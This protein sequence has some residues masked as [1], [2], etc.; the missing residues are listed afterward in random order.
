M[1]NKKQHPDTNAQENTSSRRR[2]VFAVKLMIS[3]T[4]LL[5]LI[6]Q[7]DQQDLL[8][9]VKSLPWWFVFVAWLYY[10][11]CQWISAYRWQIFL[12]VKNIHVPLSKLFSFYMVGMFLNNFLPSAVG[13]DVVKTVD[14]YRYTGRGNYAI[15]SVFLE[16]YTG[17]LGLTIIGVI[18]ALFTLRSNDS[19]IVLFSVVGTAAFLV[20]FSVL[21]WCEPLV[22][23]VVKAFSLVSPRGLAAKFKNLFEAIHSYKQHPK[24]LLLTIAVS[25]VL[26]LMFAFYYGLFAQQLGIDVDVSYFIL[27]LPVITLVTMLPLSVGGLGVREA[28]MVLLF[29]QVGIASAEILSIS[30]TVHVVNMGLSLWGGL[31]FA[32][33]GPLAKA[34]DKSASEN[35]YV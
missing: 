5:Y 32:L 23:I 7:T 2:L 12:K 11:I 6:Y 10:G 35:K 3:L 25:I 30:L 13:G 22:K 28:L 16:R 34:K 31:I 27:F 15:S 17:L 9:H 24:A 1:T 14:L 8:A 26:Q 19:W 4:I 29:A 33:R 20:A 18:A 21:L